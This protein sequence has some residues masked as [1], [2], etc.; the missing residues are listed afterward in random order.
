MLWHGDYTHQALQCV[1]VNCGVPRAVLP[2]NG[3]T[4]VYVPC[5]F[6]PTNPYVYT[7]SCIHTHAHTHTHMHIIHEAFVLTVLHSGFPASFWNLLA[8][9]Q[10]AQAGSPEAANSATRQSLQ[11]ESKVE[12]VALFVDLPPGHFAHVAFPGESW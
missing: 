2:F 6:T 11:S 4:Q 7:Y 10:T 9:V 1:Y 5:A 3:R 12:P 8:M